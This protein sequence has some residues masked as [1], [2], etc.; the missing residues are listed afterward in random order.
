MVQQGLPKPLADVA[1]GGCALEVHGGKFGEGVLV[2]VIVVLLGETLLHWL[3]VDV[4]LLC[5]S[6]LKFLKA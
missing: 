2:Q 5:D 1:V 6:P 4:Y 3:L